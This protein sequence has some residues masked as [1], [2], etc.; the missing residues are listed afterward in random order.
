[1]VETE[2]KYGDSR[3]HRRGQQPAQRQRHAMAPTWT[4]RLGGFNFH[5][6]LDACALGG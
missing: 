2:V 1:M 5:R 4:G 6:L 3:K